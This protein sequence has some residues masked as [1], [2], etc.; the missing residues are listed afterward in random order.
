LN[1]CVVPEFIS[2][3]IVTL[4]NSNSTGNTLLSVELLKNHPKNAE[5]NC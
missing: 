5:K 4:V 3:D 2:V 1:S